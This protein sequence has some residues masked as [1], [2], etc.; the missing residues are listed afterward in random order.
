MAAHSVA[1]AKASLAA[2]LIRPEPGS[3]SRTDIAQF[4]NLLDVLLLQC[5]AANIQHCKDWVLKHIGPSTIRTGAFGKYLVALSASLATSPSTSDSGQARRVII[6]CRQRQLN[7]LYLLHDILHHSKFH[8]ATVVDTAAFIEILETYITQLVAQAS[9]Y[10]SLKYSRHF[11][12]LEDLI[13]IWSEHEYY[14]SSYIAA[15]RETVAKA[16]NRSDAFAQNVALMEG[17][18][19]AECAL[20]SEDRKDAPY[21]MPSVHGDIS[22]PFYDLPAGNLMPFIVPNSLSP[23]N[24]QAVKPVALRAGPADDGLI[25]VVRAFLHDA[26]AIYETARPENDKEKWDI[27][28][29]GQPILRYDTCEAGSNGEGYYG[30]SEAFC[31]RMKLRDLR[32]PSPGSLLQHHRIGQSPRRKRRYSYSESSGSRSHSRAASRTSSSGQ[33]ARRTRRRRS[34]SDSGSRNRPKL[35]Q[36]SRSYNPGTNSRGRSDSLRS[37]TGSYSPPDVGVR[38]DPQAGNENNSTA[39]IPSGGNLQTT[40]PVP[41]FLHQGFFGPGHIP[42]PPPPPPNYQGLWPPPPPPPPVPPNFNRNVTPASASYGQHFDQAVN[43]GYQG[44]IGNP[45]S[46]VNQPWN[47]SNGAAASQGR[48]YPGR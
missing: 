18:E 48:R 47:E 37:R 26:R 30:W 9:A 35:Q 27:D 21:I 7:I 19:S 24:P 32:D 20:T 12:K 41:P 39:T 45:T 22:T 33:A 46:R 42:V 25:H 13:D 8:D 3:L 4:Q 1:I 6:S 38:E 31:K 2:S 16:F 36:S 17:S 28:E 40:S 10:N 43:Q 5:S 14:P 44:N 34:D 15:L 23:I 29:L 11:R